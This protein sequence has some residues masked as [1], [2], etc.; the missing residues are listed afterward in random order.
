MRHGNPAG[1]G[2]G[3]ERAGQRL[4]GRTLRGRLIAGLVT[5]LALACAASASS[6]TWCCAP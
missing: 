1:D 6:P 5:L 2:P 4:A 3:G